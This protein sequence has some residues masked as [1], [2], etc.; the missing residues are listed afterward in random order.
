MKT[1]IIVRHA[2]SSWDNTNVS[3]HDRTLNDRG[4]KDA[5]KMAKRVH[6]K[7]EEI[8]VLVSSTAT[9][10]LT[11]A[12]YFAE[13]F[14]IKPKNIILQPKLYL[15][16]PRSFIEV[17]SGFD[18]DWKRV[19]VFAHNPGISEFA[20]SLTNVRVDD[21]PTCAVFAVKIDTKNWDEFLSADKE[22][23]FFDYP[24]L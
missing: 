3:D 5:P 9:R 19:A 22:Y 15:A 17:I 23:F 20:N 10:A 4:K 12:K 16:E 13:E 8:D 6:E 7:I 2:K 18:N 24:K 1:L 14:D 21:M 11:T